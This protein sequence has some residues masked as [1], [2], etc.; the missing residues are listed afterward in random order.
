MEHCVTSSQLQT[1]LHLADG[2]AV[3]GE[4]EAEVL[5]AGRQNKRGDRERP[6]TEERDKGG[7]G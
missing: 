6:H 1:S 5:N 7:S 2:L 4:Q 3:K